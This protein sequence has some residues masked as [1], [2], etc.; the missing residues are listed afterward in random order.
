MDFSFPE[1]KGSPSKKKK[2]G[3]VSINFPDQ[4]E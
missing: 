1:Q 3:L 2:R 4:I